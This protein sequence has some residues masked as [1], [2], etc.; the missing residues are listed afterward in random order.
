MVNVTDRNCMGA[1][2]TYESTQI[3][4]IGIACNQ[5]LLSMQGRP[6]KITGYPLGATGV[7]V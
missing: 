7:R 3:E 6:G 1:S 4:K 2:K 5:E